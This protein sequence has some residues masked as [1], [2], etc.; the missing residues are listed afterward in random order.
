ML[1]GVV[2]VVHPGNAF[3]NIRISESTGIISNI[4]YLEE[5]YTYNNLVV[6]ASGNEN[7]VTASAQVC[8]LQ[9]NLHFHYLYALATK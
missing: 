4:E 2:I 1:E 3:D 6:H 8:I 7:Q 9:F 5:G